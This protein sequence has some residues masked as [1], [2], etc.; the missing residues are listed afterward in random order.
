MEN[1]TL[2]NIIATREFQVEGR[3]GGIKVLLGRPQEWGN[4]RDYY[5]PYQIVGTGKEEVK[6]AFGVDAIQSLQLVMK[7]I[8]A[9]V[10]TLPEAK[11]GILKWDG[12]EEGDF[13]FPKS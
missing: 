8:G 5:C 6:K 11:K 10:Y 7:M 13:G 9:E 2:E 1:I 12:G 4:G 3:E